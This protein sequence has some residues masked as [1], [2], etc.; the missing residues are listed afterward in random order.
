MNDTIFLPSIPEKNDFEFDY[1]ILAWVT[2]PS[3][4]LWVLV[5]LLHVIV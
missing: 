3:D 2:D 1:G 4:S 5:E